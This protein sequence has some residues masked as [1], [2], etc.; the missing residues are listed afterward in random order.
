MSL[1]QTY[2]QLE[3]KLNIALVVSVGSG[4]FPPEELGKVDAHQFLFFGKHWLKA[5]YLIKKRS[6][7]LLSLLTTAVSHISN[8][9]KAK[10]V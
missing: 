5:G 10:I 4:I 6:K 8:S 7:N 3:V 1:I 9:Y 2:R